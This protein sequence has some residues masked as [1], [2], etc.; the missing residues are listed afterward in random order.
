MLTLP[1][2][3][4]KGD[5][6]E[7]H[8]GGGQGGGGGVGSTG[9]TIISPNHAFVQSFPFLCQGPSSTLTFL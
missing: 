9:E 3:L 7:G 8:D 2:L 1:F 5:G 4:V 6:G